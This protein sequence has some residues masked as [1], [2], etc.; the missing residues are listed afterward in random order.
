MPRPLHGLLCALLSCYPTGDA[1]V[2]LPEDLVAEL[3]RAGVERTIEPR[4]S[5]P[6]TYRSPG[7]EH[8]ASSALLALAE[9]A[10]SQIHLE[11]A[12]SPLRTAALID[13]LWADDR[14]IPLERSIAY[15]RTA[16]RLADRPAPVLTDLAGGLAAVW[17][18]V[19]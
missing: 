7:G 10:S 13:L 16:S 15:L 18:E 2:S 11:V 12:P 8:A 14:R 4:L 17:Q 6:M 1:S 3:A 9:R 5:I 19:H